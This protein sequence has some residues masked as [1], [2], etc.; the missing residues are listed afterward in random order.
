MNLVDNYTFRGPW[1]SLQVR[2]G[3]VVRSSAAGIERRGRQNHLLASIPRVESGG[4]FQHLELVSTRV[5]QVLYECGSRSEYVFFPT[6]A[7]ISLVC[8]A[9]DGGVAEVATVGN[10][11]MVGVSL[12]LGDGVNTSRAVI[13]RGGYACRIKAQFLKQAFDGSAIVRQQLLRYAQALFAQT[14]Q[15]VL[16]N[17]HHTVEQRLCR[18]LLSMLDR[19]SSNEM[20]LTQEMIANALGVRR[21]GVTEA[22]GELQRQGAIRYSRGNIRVVDRRCLEEQACECYGVV[23]REYERLLPSTGAAQ[24]GV[25]AERGDESASVRKRTDLQVGRF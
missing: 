23:R 17:R 25:K 12:F 2:P 21:S 22:A 4:L 14:A 16:C 7:V 3:R 18:W 9:L 1:Q 13:Q 11:G 5:G 10:E 15:A 19:L 8:L 20:T 24:S 6:D